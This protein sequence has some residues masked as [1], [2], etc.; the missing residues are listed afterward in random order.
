MSIHEDTID[1]NK[2]V[3]IISNQK[4]ATLN[5]RNSSFT[6]IELESDALNQAAN[7]VRIDKH[8]EVVNQD[9]Y[10][11]YDIDTNTKYIVVQTAY[12]YDGTDAMGMNTYT[13]VI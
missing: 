8:K 1:V 5:T 3:K 10:Y 4:N 11:Y 13:A 7:I 9:I 2:I 6:N 12:Y